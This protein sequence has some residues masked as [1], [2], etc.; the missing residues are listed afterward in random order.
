MAKSAKSH[1]NSI[2]S[3]TAIGHTGN[4]RILGDAPSA[5]FPLT[6]DNMKVNF[7]KVL[8]Q[9]WNCDGNQISAYKAIT[10]RM[11]TPDAQF[12]YPYASLYG[13]EA[14]MA[15]WSVFLLGRALSRLD[16]YR[17]KEDYNW[18]PEKL[19]L[20]YQVEAWQHYT[21]MP[22]LNWALGRI[23]AWKVNG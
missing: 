22:L 11:Y 23:P 12:H 21:W 9:F 4:I 18:D 10:R 17:R 8:D 2:S 14:V 13:R 6:R 20:I 7:P 19:Q 16:V 1:A 3:G 5:H 15:F